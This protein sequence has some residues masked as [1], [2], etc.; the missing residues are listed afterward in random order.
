MAD[1]TGPPK[2]VSSDAAP[3]EGATQIVNIGPF[4]FTGTQTQNQPTKKPFCHSY[5]VSFATAMMLVAIFDDPL[6][7]SF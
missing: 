4:I 5:C 1:F 3:S 2:M 7:G 6:L